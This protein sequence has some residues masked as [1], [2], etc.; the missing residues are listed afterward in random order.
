MNTS[1]TTKICQSPAEAAA[2][3]RDGALVALPTETVYGLG[4]DATNPVSVAGI[5]ESKQRPAFDPLI[6]HVPD[7]TMVDKVVAEF[8]HTAR[9]LAEAFWPGPLT[10][11]LPKRPEI[12]D[13]VTAGLPGVGIRVPG[14]P[15]TCEV[16][17]LAG[18]PVA[19]PSANPFS[20][21]SPTT[22]QHVLDG[23]GGRIDAVLD[24]GPCLVGVES[25]VLSLMTPIPTL[26]RPGGVTREAIERVIGPVDVA[27][28]DPEQDDQAQ[29]A[30]GML[31]RHYAPRTPLT[32][33]DSLNEA[34]PIVGKPTG[35]LTYGRPAAE[36][37]AD[38]FERVEI[39]CEQ[40]DLK[41]CAAQLFAGLRRLDA[42]GLDAI[43]AIR[44]PSQG[45]GVAL[46]DR[47]QRAA[48]K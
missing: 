41:N 39:L 45:L 19:A 10:L 32:V 16:L 7:V 30:P 3:L 44:F 28:A 5:F 47:L 48:S 8:P 23:L 33:V 36:T 43:I 6:V 37:V 15:L 2:L 26:L 17:R 20:G 21:I 1:K 9:Q 25:T 40:A 4:A 24:G 35:L 12:S 11:V 27:V 22:A 34:I 14:H 13:L 31:S 42:A 18:C 29:P 38:G 46:N